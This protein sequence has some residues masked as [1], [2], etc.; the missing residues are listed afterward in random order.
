VKEG[1]VLFENM[2]ESL[3]VVYRGDKLTLHTGNGSVNVSIEVTARQDGG[4]GEIISIVT[5]DNKLY[6]GK[7]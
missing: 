6:K 7:I 1:T 5:D 2:I 3:P 4:I